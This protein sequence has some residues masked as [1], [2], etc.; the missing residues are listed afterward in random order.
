[1]NRIIIL[2]VVMTACGLG[3]QPN[4]YSISPDGTRSQRYSRVNESSAYGTGGLG[5]QK[6]I[7]D[8]YEKAEHA[9]PPA[10]DVKIYNAS[11]PPGVT[12]GDGVVKIDKDAPYEAVGRFEIGYWLD[13]APNEPDVK[14][15]LVRL[16]SVTGGSTVVVEVQHPNHAD[17]RVQ[18]MVGFILR[19]RAVEA[20]APQAARP[21]VRAKLSYEASARGCLSVGEFADEVSARLGY[22]PWAA[23]APLSLGARIIEQGGTFKATITSPRGAPKQLTGA[24]CRTVTDAAVAVLVV[25]LDETP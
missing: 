4:Y 20:A 7:S 9:A 6:T 23:D 8:A 22:S 10:L 12:L 18:Y 24:T 15:D 25:R 17:P 3:R 2:C 16:A 1:M 19:A 5:A 14:D 13:S 21:H 11:L